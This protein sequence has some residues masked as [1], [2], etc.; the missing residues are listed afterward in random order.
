MCAEDETKME[1][2]D[3]DGEGVQAGECRGNEVATGTTVGSAS[4]DSNSSVSCVALLSIDGAVSQ[5][6]MNRGKGSAAVTVTGMDASLT[7]CSP[8]VGDT[9]M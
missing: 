4:S 1:S 6:S 8:E 9:S 2:Q 3:E 7:N 5:G